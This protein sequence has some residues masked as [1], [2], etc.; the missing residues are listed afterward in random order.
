M[1]WISL[2]RINIP[3]P[4]PPL[5]IQAMLF[6]TLCRRARS[7]SA[8]PASKVAPAKR[9]LVNSRLPYVSA[10]KAFWARSFVEFEEGPSSFSISSYI[11]CPHQCIQKPALTPCSF[12]ITFFFHCSSDDFS[13]S[14]NESQEA[15]DE[16]AADDSACAG[17][18]AL[19][20]NVALESL[21]SAPSDPPLQPLFRL[22]LVPM[23]LLMT[24]LL[25]VV[26]IFL[27]IF[28]WWLR[29]WRRP[30]VFVSL[31]RKSGVVLWQ[32]SWFQSLVRA[33]QVE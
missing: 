17:S 22:M 27:L 5:T 16:W 18:V 12:S 13:A 23:R 11:T 29:K 10:Y 24:L 33:V 25:P 20:D 3:L 6:A 15:I 14:N 30:E 4:D 2:Y 7:R 1:I 26:L 8:N 28:L 21:S 19:D 31:P 9:L 32:F